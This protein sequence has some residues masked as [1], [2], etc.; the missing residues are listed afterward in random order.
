[1]AQDSGSLNSPVNIALPQTATGM[2]KALQPYFQDV[3]DAIFQL[4]LALVNFVGISSQPQGL[5]NQ[6]KASQTIFAQNGGRFYA[7]AAEAIGPGAIVNVF[8]SAGAAKVQNANATNNTK[9]AHGYCNVAAG[10]A[11]GDYLEVILFSGLCTLFSGLTPGQ[12]YF[13][14]TVAGSIQIAEPVA[15]GNIGQFVGIA[16]DANSLFFNPSFKWLQH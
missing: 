16:L 9:Q 2:D 10:V 11:L 14:S 15:A 6:L 4:Q 3:Y 13:L 12:M 8:N 7:Q 1:M 5:W